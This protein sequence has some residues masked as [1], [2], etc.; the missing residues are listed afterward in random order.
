[1]K[2]EIP[3]DRALVENAKYA[4]AAELKRKEKMNLPV[5]KFDVKSGEIAMHHG[6]GS[7]TILSQGSKRRRYSERCREKT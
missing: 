2:H 7:I 5:A 3:S 6:D 4:V 1:M